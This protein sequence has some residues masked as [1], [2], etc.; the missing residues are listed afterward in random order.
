LATEIVAGEAG[1]DDVAERYIS[2]RSPA[3][4]RSPCRHTWLVGST[5]IARRDGRVVV[6][7]GLGQNLAGRHEPV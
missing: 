2:V 4:A 7:D 6:Y 1:E 5:L 3:V